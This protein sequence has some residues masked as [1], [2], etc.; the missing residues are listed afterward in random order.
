MR[1][2]ATALLAALVLGG[3]PVSAAE[4]RPL[5]TKDPFYDYDGHQPLAKV[6][7]GTVL[8]QRAVTVTL[9]GTDGPWAAE[10][11]LYRTRD[12]HGAPTVTVTTVIEPTAAQPSGGL[13]AYLSFYDGFGPQCDPSYTLAGGYPGNQTNQSQAEEEGLLIAHYLAA[14]QP[15]T[16]PDFEGEQHHWGAGQESGYAT[17]DA[18]VA[19]ESFLDIDRRTRVV[20]SGYSGGAIAADWA[21]ELART[22]HPRQL[23]LVG[24]AEGGI[25]V[26]YAH[27]LRYVDG[28]ASY[29]G[30]ILGVL[31]GVGRAFPFNL[32]K[33]LS[34]HG[35][36]L[37]AEVHDQCIATFLGSHPGLRLRDV[38]KRKYRDLYAVRSF[39]RPLNHLIMGRHRSHPDVPL[40]MGVGDSDG[41][42]DG[43]MLVGDVEALAHQYCRQ[44]ANV[45]FRSY[46]GLGHEVAGAE[47]EPTATDFL[48]ERLEGTPFHGNCDTIGK[49]NSIKPLP[50]PKRH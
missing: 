19:T 4:E 39:V 34:R 12:E 29:S 40:F 35:R 49:G 2:L 15:V 13:I 37:I 17:L 5:P 7:A 9:G 20:L 33:H 42:G 23:H 30:T 8:K 47:F 11:L 27:N 44:G 16:V 26:D 38:V 41:T 28:S 3:T 32:H 22:Y 45:L 36:R 10:Q 1:W 48:L 43:V 6:P 50:V 31:M 14:G 46:Q 24:V 18:I 25:P 21:S